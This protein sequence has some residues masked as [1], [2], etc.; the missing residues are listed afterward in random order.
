MQAEAEAEFVP[1]GAE[2][3]ADGRWRDAGDDA[4]ADTRQRFQMVKHIVRDAP[5]DAITFG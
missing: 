2:P 1:Q 5:D 4:L 3:A